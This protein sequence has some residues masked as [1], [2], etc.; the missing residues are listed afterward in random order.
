MCQDRAIGFSRVPKH[1]LPAV[2]WAK[3]THGLP[4][5]RLVVLHCCWLRVSSRPRLMLLCSKT[6]RRSML[7]VVDIYICNQQ[8]ATGAE[9]A[10]TLTA[11]GVHSLCAYIRTTHALLCFQVIQLVNV[12]R[13]GVEVFRRPCI[14]TTSTI[15]TPITRK[16]RYKKRIEYVP[17]YTYTYM[18]SKLRT[19]WKMRDHLHDSNP[20]NRSQI[21]SASFVARP[22]PPIRQQRSLQ[23]LDV[24]L[25]R[26][27]QQQQQCAAGIS[28]G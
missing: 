24:F 14:P 1:C 15:V 13:D 27:A 3:H 7:Y 25:S 9:A 22:P 10:T 8:S 28:Y 23:P 21:S 17:M 19:D 18:Q 16:A 4:Q 6:C 26:T 11:C 20:W 12:F 2:K 5:V